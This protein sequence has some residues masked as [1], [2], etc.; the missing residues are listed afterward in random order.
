VPRPREHILA[1]LE[2]L[3]R[4]SFAAAAERGDADEKRRL[5]FG[6]RRDQL[7]LEALLDVRDLLARPA[8]P[9]EPTTTTDKS[10]LEQINDLRS[11]T[12]R[13]PFGR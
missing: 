12:Q 10:V 8:A 7:Y 4:E 2:S 13:F 3:Y 9:D 5:D 6:F 11:L 1:N